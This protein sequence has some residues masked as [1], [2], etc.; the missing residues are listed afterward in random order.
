VTKQGETVRTLSKWYTGSEKPAK[1]IARVSNLRET[2]PLKVG[3]RVL[4]PTTY[5]RKTSPPPKPKARPKSQPIVKK[6]DGV[7]GAEMPGEEESPEP[8]ALAAE[9][10]PS[11]PGAWTAP[12]GL[13]AEDVNQDP[14]VGDVTTPSSD[15]RAEGAIEAG[16]AVPKPVESFE[17]LLLKEQLEVERIRREMQAVPAAGAAAE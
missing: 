12:S 6:D 1:E 10:D 13:G 15:A 14:H 4:I 17:E 9:P 8:V 2:T 3:Q 16:A 5:V 7:D 11:D